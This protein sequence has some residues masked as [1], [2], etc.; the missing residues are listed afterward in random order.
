M[1]ETTTLPPAYMPPDKACQ[2]FGVSRTRLYDFAR[3]DPAIIV[4][5]GGR[6]LVDVERLKALIASMPRGPRKANGGG[7][8]PP[9]KT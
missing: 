5:M 3:I 6:S 7:K 8:G 1:S 2:Y 4:Q 9:R